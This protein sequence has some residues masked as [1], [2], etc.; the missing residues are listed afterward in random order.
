MFCLVSSNIKCYLL[1]TT[2]PSI[3]IEN[4]NTIPAGTVV[5]VSFPKITNPAA[6]F[7]AHVKTIKLY[8]RIRTELNSVWVTFSVATPPLNE[9]GP[10]GNSLYSLTSYKV[11][12]FTNIT[13][14]P[15]ISSTLNGPGTVIIEFPF[16]DIGWIPSSNTI[17]CKLDT[18]YYPCTRYDG[19]DWITVSLPAGV[20]YP[21]AKTVTIENVRIPRHN[22]ATLKG[23]T[24]RYIAGTTR[25]ETVTRPQEFFSTSS[26]IIIPQVPV[27]HQSLLIANKKSKGAVNAQYT[28]MF[29]SNNE[30]PQG[31]SIII[32]FPPEYNILS[33]Y[34]PVQFSSPDLV[35]ISSTQSVTFIPNVQTLTITGYKT[36]PAKTSFTINIE[37]LRNP[38]NDAVSDGWKAEVAFNGGIMVSESNFDQFTFTPALNPG[39]ITFN[40]IK[41]FPLNAGE[42][43]DYTISFVPATEIPVGGQIRIDFPIANFPSLPSPPECSVSDGITTFASCT[44]TGNTYT[45]ELD[46]KYSTDGISITI[47]NIPNPSVGTT[48]GF[49]V[50]TFYD[51]TYLDNTAASD[52]AGRTVTIVQPTNALAVQELSCDPRNEGEPSSYTF[53]FLPTNPITSSMQILITFPEVYDPRLGDNIDCSSPT[54]L[55]GDV[56]CVIKNRVVIIRGFDPY[57]PDAD[58]PITIKIYGVTN[59]NQDINSN[60]GNFKIATYYTNTEIFVDSNNAAGAFEPLPA[61][62][63]STLFN[64]SATNLYA[65]IKAD[66]TFNFT[67]FIGIPSTGSQGAIL[68]DFP[69]DF[70]L[71]AQSL[72]CESKTATFSSS[73]SCKVDRNRVTVKGHANAYT[74]GVRFTVNKISNPVEAGTAGNIVLKVYDGFNALIV[75]RSYKNLDP[76]SFAYTFPGPQITANNNLTIRVER[77]TQTKDLYLTLDYPCA[78]NLTIRPTTPGF[79]VIPSSIPFLLGMIKT[80]FRVSVSEDFPEGTYE[81]EWE[82]L[83]DLDP[84]FYTPIKNT[85]VIVTSLSSKIFFPIF[86]F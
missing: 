61:P 86:L 39:T 44:L 21:P 2:A 36:H 42:I 1:P 20:N 3:R 64:V 73:L 59:P 9:N 7:R 12:T 60:T 71:A 34:P 30:L 72:V 27:F 49:V 35:D 77:G 48:D 17:G 58:N 54:G 80:K 19:A 26:P 15:G 40:S 29:T 38:A 24:F 18:T 47:K 70:Q 68:V 10:V 66:Y 25:H 67:S 50:Y 79:N 23:V 74:G 81:I 6:D 28:M 85:K 5:S 52:L 8:N 84:P 11:S 75:E 32:T 57:T 46:S 83:N 41:A 55:K 78:L 37:G 14:N 43:A 69:S 13:F 4:F 31:S 62:S 56:G 51:G 33:S 16:Y 53:V 82:T 65:R 76:F 22:L 63:W 45:I